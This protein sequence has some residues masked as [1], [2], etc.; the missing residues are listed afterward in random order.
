M[1]RLRL[2]LRELSLTQ[3]LVTIVFLVISFFA[4]FIFAYLSPQINNFAGNEMYRML[5]NSQYSV[6]YYLNQYPSAS[7]PDNQATTIQQLIYDPLADSFSNGQLQDEAFLN[8]VRENILDG[9]E[10]TEDDVFSVSLG[11]FSDVDI[12]Y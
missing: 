6:S 7:L 8:G 10:G 9:V 12:Y 5:H 3:Q 4:L 1:K 11:R 2:W